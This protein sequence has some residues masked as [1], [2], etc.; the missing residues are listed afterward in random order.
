MK[1]F[2]L[3]TRTNLFE[4]FRS[5]RDKK[6]II[7]LLLE[8]LKQLLILNNEIKEFKDLK[9][10]DNEE[11]M[12]IVVCIDKMKRLF[13]CTKNKVQTFCFP[14]NIIA[15]DNRIEFYYNNS[16]IDL[17][18]I[19]ILIGVFS[20]SP[21]NN[22]LNLV[23]SLLSEECYNKYSKEEQNL[24]EELVLFLS[25]FEDGYLRFDFKDE[26]NFDE[27]THPKDHI[28]FFYTNS[29]TF[30]LGINSE[31]SLKEII[32]IIDINQKCLHVH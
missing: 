20:N 21:M 5:I 30:K 11:E 18:K 23:E 32:E 12:R 31:I 2:E 15:S 19:S 25:I 26:E 29:N 3:K 6:C 24:L 1:K 22:S 14:F 10:I 8:T 9:I 16:E 13:Y 28:D 27:E 4:E 17:T 7:L